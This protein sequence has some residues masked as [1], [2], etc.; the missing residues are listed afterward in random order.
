MFSIGSKFVRI[1]DIIIAEV[2]AADFFIPDLAIRLYKCCLCHVLPSF[3]ILL[4]VPI[5]GN[6]MVT[7]F[8]FKLAFCG[9]N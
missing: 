3:P 8:R 2:S 5:S 4:P 1:S 9:F 7:Q 6:E